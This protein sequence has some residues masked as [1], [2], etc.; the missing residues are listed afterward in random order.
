MRARLF[1]TPKTAAVLLDGKARTFDL[2]RP[3]L[4]TQL[5]NELEDLAKTGRGNRVAFGFQ[6]A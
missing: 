2:S 3:T 5:G 1:D 4:S 6:S